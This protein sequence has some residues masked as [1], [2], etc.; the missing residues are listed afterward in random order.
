VDSSAH[1]AAFSLP[2]AHTHTHRYIYIYLLPHN[3]PHLYPAV[4]IFMAR[5]AIVLA[6]DVT[7]RLIHP[8]LLDRGSSSGVSKFIL[9]LES[10]SP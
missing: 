2:H 1:S 8:R 3:Y 4:L 5:E 7:A 9:A 10:A 6:C